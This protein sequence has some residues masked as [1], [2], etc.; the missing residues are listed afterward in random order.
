[1]PSQPQSRCNTWHLWAFILLL[2]T[3][4]FCI[5]FSHF[6][7]F[8]FAFDIHFVSIVLFWLFQWFRLF[9]F[10]LLSTIILLCFFCFFCSFCLFHLFHFGH[11]ILMFQVL[12]HANLNNHNN[13]SFR[14]HHSYFHTFIIVIILQVFLPFL[15][16]FPLNFI[17]WQCTV[18]KFQLILQFLIPFFQFWFLF[19]DLWQT[20][21]TNCTEYPWNPWFWLNW[22]EVLSIDKIW[23]RNFLCKIQYLNSLSYKCIRRTKPPKVVY[24]FS[25]KL[26]GLLSLSWTKVLLL[27]I[28]TLS[29]TD[30][31]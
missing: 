6:R 12:V 27:V 25:S 3:F 10:V 8:I 24:Q 1:M 19:C 14:L 15:N 30:K 26:P 9:H 28:F 21:N 31:G 17:L 22:A 23:E 16:S 20:L 7:C 4:F 11:F 2:L 18:L 13:L 5:F 29:L